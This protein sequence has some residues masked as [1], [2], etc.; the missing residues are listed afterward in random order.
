MRVCEL[1]HALAKV[2]LDDLHAERLEVWVELDLLARHR[3]DLGHHRTLLPTRGVPADLADDLARL[4]RV[5]CVVRLAADRLQALREC[6]Y[7]LGQSLEVC[8]S[9]FLEIR[10]T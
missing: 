2:R 6:F 8:P 10:A 5:L 4:G 9:A 1:H 7:Q 3:L